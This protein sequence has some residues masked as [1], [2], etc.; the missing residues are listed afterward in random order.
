VTIRPL[1]AVTRASKTDDYLESLRR[2]G[3]EPVLVDAATGLSPP[4]WR[5]LAGVLLSGGPDVDPHRYGAER[6]PTYEPAEQGRDE[7]ELEL[8]RRAIERD[9]PLFGICRGAQVLNVAAG[10]TLVQNIPTE[11]PRPLE[12]RVKS[13]PKFAHDVQVTPDSVLRQA[14]SMPDGQEPPAIAVNSRHHQ[15]V[16]DLAPSLVA[17][18][19]A[20][21][22]VI[23]G[24]ER[25]AARYCLGVQ[26]HPENFWRTGEFDALFRSFVRACRL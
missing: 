20:A 26:W 6:D 2:A 13:A 14:L 16:K 7:F 9:L 23:E 11:I 18:A 3:A 10:G 8:A 1:I 22:G 12:H 5:D 19:V 24:I 21:D 17:V 15:A 25:P 4:L